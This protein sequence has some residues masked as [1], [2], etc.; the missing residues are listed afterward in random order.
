MD[1]VIKLDIQAII[2]YLSSLGITAEKG[3]TV[4][5]IDQEQLVV[6]LGVDANGQ[7]RAVVIVLQEPELEEGE[8][9]QPDDIRLIKFI[10][11]M[12]VQVV[13]DASNDVARLVS[14]LNHMVEFPGFIYTETMHSVNFLYG[15]PVVGQRIQGQQ[16]VSVIGLIGSMIDLYQETIQQI[17]S[18]KISFEQLL[19]QEPSE[20]EEEV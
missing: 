9:E 8:V 10:G 18:G 4:E 12:V 1:Q 7:E 13:P 11:V 2:D 15:L 14:F 5:G 19:T 20:E 17:A 3:E 16:L 6:P